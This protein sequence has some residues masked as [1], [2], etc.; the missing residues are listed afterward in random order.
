[1]TIKNLRDQIDKI[2]TEITDLFIKR[3]NIAKQV[4]E[5]KKPPGFPY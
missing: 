3:M 1:M 2:D 5:E 4:A